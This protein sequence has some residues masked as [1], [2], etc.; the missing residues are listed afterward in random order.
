[1]WRYEGR[2]PLYLRRTVMPDIDWNYVW[3]NE[4]AA[5]E[6]HGQPGHYGDH[7]GDPEKEENLRAIV[8]RYI[9][10][11]IQ[12]G[13]TALEIGSGGGRWTQYLLEFSRLYSVELNVQSF[14]YLLQR[15]GARPNLSFCKTNGTDFPGV[16]PRSID[17]VFSFDVFVHLDPELIFAYLTNVRALLKPTSTLFIHYADQTKPGVSGIYGFSMTDSPIMRALVAK[18][19]YSVLEEDTTSL[20]HSNILRLA[21]IGIPAATESGVGSVAPT[22]LSGSGAIQSFKL[23]LSCATVQ[24]IVEEKR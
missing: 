6:S 7:W 20:W 18:A 17:F 8:T 9:K 5:W 19:G 1:M 11:F 10:P 13:H 23:D 16:P 15:F 21:P 22:A 14:H 24:V 4:I 2:T 3:G 12:P